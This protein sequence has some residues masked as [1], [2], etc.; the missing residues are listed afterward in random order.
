[1]NEF[2]KWSK[3]IE[4]IFINGGSMC[5]F[6]TLRQTNMLQKNSYW[7]TYY[8]SV[9]ACMKKFPSEFTK[10]CVFQSYSFPLSKIPAIFSTT[11]KTLSAYLLGKTAVVF[12][13]S[14][15]YISNTLLSYS[16]HW[17]FYLEEEKNLNWRDQSCCLTYFFPA[18]LYSTN[19][20]PEEIMHKLETFFYQKRYSWNA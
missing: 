12:L 13:S 15:F 19:V 5:N 10:T 14:Y 16:C 20:I 9:V 3:G 7:R 4:W 6:P 1:M 18:T 8:V 17:G 11:S 2:R